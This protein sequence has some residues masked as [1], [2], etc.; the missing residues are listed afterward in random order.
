MKVET[1]AKIV[2]NRTKL[3]ARA[4]MQLEHAYRQEV[5]RPANPEEDAFK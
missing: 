5:P 1:T 3:L 4:L 2:V